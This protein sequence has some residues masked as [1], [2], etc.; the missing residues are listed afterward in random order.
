M[1][2]GMSWWRAF[3]PA[4]AVVSAVACAQG[5]AATGASWPEADQL[6]RNDPL[7]LGSDGDYSC[8]LGNG[9]VLWLFGDTLIARDATRNQNTA[10]F[11]HNSIAIETGYDP[12]QAF[13]QFYWS[14]SNGQPDA[15]FPGTGVQW[16]WPGACA[17]VGRGLIIFAGR[18]QNDGPPGP[19]SFVGVGDGAFFVADADADPSTWTPQDAHAPSLNPPIGLGTAATIS[20]DYL[21]AYGLRDG[22]SHDYVIVRFA[23]SDAA[24]GDLSKGEFFT[25]GHWVSGSALNGLPDAIF[26]L[27]AP[28]SSVSWE[29]LLGLFVMAQSVGYGSTTLALRSA[30][31]PQGPW[32]DAR[33]F[34]R[35]PESNSPNAFVYAGKGHPELT[36][37]DFVATY[38]PSSFGGTPP[39]GADGYARFVKVTF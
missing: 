26:D 35:P 13:I 15:F 20:G 37:A 27:G 7:W 33:T 14:Q 11:I 8:D 5:P 23:L 10:Y 12:S 22:D 19:F 36:G 38:F 34:F 4:L 29:P 17:R 18:V 32:T 6:F 30:L 9:R 16:F 28:E 31:A 3:L 21:Y 24:A 39:P 1:V 2:A 25:G